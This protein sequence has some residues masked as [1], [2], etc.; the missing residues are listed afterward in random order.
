MTRKLGMRGKP[1]LVKVVKAAA[2]S[3]FRAAALV[4]A[5]SLAVYRGLDVGTIVA[6]IEV[7]WGYAL[8]YA[9]IGAVYDAVLGAGRT[10]WRFASIPDLLSIVKIETVTILTF[11]MAV[12]VLDRALLLPRSTLLLAWILDIAFLGSVLV[13]RRAIHDGDLLWAVLPRPNGQRPGRDATALLLVGG[14]DR[15]DMFLRD[16]ARHPAEYRPMGLVTANKDDVGRQL[17]GVRV[18][19]SLDGLERVL[20]GFADNEGARGAVLFIDDNIAPADIDSELLGR[21]RR[22]GV[23]FLRMSRIVEMA[24][25]SARPQLYEVNVE[26]LLSRPPVNLD[27]TE[28]RNLISGRRV[29]VTGA[30]GSIGSEI[31]RQAAALGCAHISLLDNSEFALFRVDMEISDKYPTLSRREILCDIRDPER[32]R[33]WISS[34][35]P[36]II[37][38]TA[39]LKHVPLVESHACEGVLTNVV[40]TWNVASAAKALGVDHMV[41]ISTDKAVD[42]GNVMG[43]TKRIAESVVRLHQAGSSRTRFSVVRFGNVLGSA[44]SVVPTFKAQIERGGPITVTHPDIERYFMTIPEAVQ[45]VLHA[46]ARAASRNGEASGVFVLDMGQPVKIMSLAHRLIELYGKVPGRD[47][48]IQITGLRPG[49]KLTEELVDSTEDAL[50]AEAGVIEVRDRAAGLLISRD[51]V[52]QLEAMARR[53]DGDSMR[54]LLFQVLDTIR[55]GQVIDGQ[56]RI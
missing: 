26:E 30:G 7:V 39:A 31:C 9:A 52:S 13:L 12:F 4:V 11:L 1:V 33:S 34:E 6:S 56:F 41:L 8:V 27:I 24:D 51:R 40:G 49:E 35:A 23:R 20:D 14:L 22:R 28:I 36:E 53:G 37:F 18:L 46:T 19:A 2:R 10:P 55:S 5:Y 54:V 45:L 29:M 16:H 47:I 3:V 48:E 38:H 42:P 21:A 32:V 15:A 17:R 25:Q 44:G 50:P 43:A